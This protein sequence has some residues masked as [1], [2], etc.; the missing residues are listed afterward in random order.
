MV[1]INLISWRAEKHAYEE[2]ILR[3]II[4]G[5]VA[6][7]MIIMITAHIILK[8]AVRQDQQRLHH[9]TE[10]LPTVADSHAKINIITYST[11]AELAALL[12]AAAKTIGSGVC[13]QRIAKE[14]GGWVIEGRALTSQSMLSGLMSLEKMPLSAGM[15]LRE[16]KKDAS[17]DVYQFVIQMRR[18]D[19]HRGV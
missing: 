17:H 16:L 9:F 7:A 15:T 2:K 12:D 14:D 6:A 3:Q 13:Y 19:N 8:A 5:S 18:A 11:T 10:I 1:E 4:A